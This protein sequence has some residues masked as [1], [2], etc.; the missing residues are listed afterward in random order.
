MNEATVLQWFARAENDLKAG[1]G[2]F[3]SVNPATDTICFHMQQCV[4]KYLKGFLVFHGKEIDKTHNLTLILMK[5]ADVDP[6]FQT[7]VD[8]EV[9]RLT[10]YATVLRYP[11]D[12]YMPDGDETRR[13]I[14]LAEDCR[15]FV[16]E[17]LREKGFTINGPAQP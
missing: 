4:E 12:F 1:K 17:R 14:S 5:C 8:A 7:M 6:S 2:E 16:L 3:S 11:D 9:D 15:S 10:P 13:A